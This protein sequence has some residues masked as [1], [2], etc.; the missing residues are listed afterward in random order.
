MQTFVPATHRAD[1]DGI[2]EAARLL[3]RGRL[4]A[5]PTETV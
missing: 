3:A 1:A 5:F 4:V 2:A